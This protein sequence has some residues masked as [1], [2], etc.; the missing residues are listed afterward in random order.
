MSEENLLGSYLKARRMRMDAA[1]L[2]YPMR[3]RRTPGLRREEIAIR[4]NVSTTWYTWLEQGRGGAPSAEVLERLARALALSKAER[5]HL[6]LLAQ[7][8]P[9]RVQFQETDVTPQLQR[10]LDAMPLS[11]AFIKTADW[12]IVA[13]NHA[14]T[15]VFTDYARLPVTRRNI[16]WLVFCEEDVKNKIPDWE[17]VAGSLVASFR[18]DLARTGASDRVKTLVQ[19]LCDTSPQFCAFWASQDVSLHGA[20][21]KKIQYPDVGMLTLEYTTLS[22][23]GKPG[24]SMVIYN[25]ATNDDFVLMQHL[26]NQHE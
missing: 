12:Q 20:G 25:P 4:A 19:L 9:P 7:H 1:Q 18:A 17:K 3:R 21:L 23:E 14:A 15:R 11:P 13:W 10:V 24:L 8:R 5:E 6:F 22:V 26:L 16:L 2:G